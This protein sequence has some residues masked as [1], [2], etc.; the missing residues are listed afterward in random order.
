MSEP[1]AGRKPS[2]RGASRIG[3]DQKVADSC[4]TS[5]PPPDAGRLIVS[6]PCGVKSALYLDVPPSVAVTEDS[7]NVQEP[8]GDVALPEQSVAPFAE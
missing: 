1:R 2:E 4:A 7:V 5:V 3:L 8:S 6:E